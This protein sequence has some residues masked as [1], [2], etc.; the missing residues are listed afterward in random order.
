[1]RPWARGLLAAVSISVVSGFASVSVA[2]SAFADDGDGRPPAPLVHPIWSQLPDAPDRD[3]ARKDF[4][5]AVTRYKLGGVEIIDVPAPPPPRAADALKVGST[6]SSKLDHGAALEQLDGAA[7]E[8]ATTGGAG[9]TTTELSDLYVYRAMSTAAATWNSPATPPGG[10]SIADQARARAFEDYKRAATLTPDRALNPRDIPPQ[11]LFDFKRA[12]DEVKA[13]PRG[14]LVVR[15]SA[16]AQVSFDGAP[17]ARVAGGITFR[18]VVF[19]DHLVRVEELGRAPWGTVLTMAAPTQELEIPQ[20]TALALDDAVA[21]SHA[22]RMGAKFALVAE[23][24]PGTGARLELRLVDVMGVKHDSALIA[25]GAE[26]GQ[27]DASVMRLDEQA[28]RIAQLGLAPGEVGGPPLPPEPASTATAPPPTLLAPPPRAPAT[29]QEDPA[30]WAR[31][32]WPLLTA[33]GV[34]VLTALILTVTVAADR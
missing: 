25:P 18:D 9:L 15:G 29:F 10:D 28:R 1:M 6:K 24:K 17:L 13:R 30:A 23:P 2:A 22:R 34:V 4:A 26:H 27:I 3:G 11:V 31:D 5:A 21:A 7:A 14:T 19:G 32:H 12:A 33:T 16:D 20:R 8:V